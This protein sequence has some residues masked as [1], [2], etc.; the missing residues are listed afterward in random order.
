METLFECRTVHDKAWAKELYGFMY[1][2]RTAMVVIHIV[3]TLYF[4]Y[5]VYDLLKWGEV[6]LFLL[7]LP[8]LFIGLA[9]FRY[10][11][12]IKLTLKRQKEMCG[13]K[14][15]ESVSTVTEEAVVQK[16]SNGAE[17][18]LH[19]VDVK[20]VIHTKAYFYIWSKTNVI[21]TLAKDGFTVG[22]PEGFLAFLKQKG[23]KVK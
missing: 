23:I 1:F 9:V 22:S 19:Y 15:P 14:V 2:K 5:G 18:V 13:E 20:K 3:F 4:L 11:H 8:P 10:F 7:I 21:Y 6:S 16:A 12:S 17:L